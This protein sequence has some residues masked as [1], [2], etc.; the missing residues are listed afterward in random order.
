ML[1][2]PPCAELDRCMLT[3]NQ[4]LVVFINSVYIRFFLGHLTNL[5]PYTVQ[6]DFEPAGRPGTEDDYYQNFKQNICVVCGSK[7]SY[8]RKMIV[9]RDYRRHFPP[10]MKDH[11]SHDILLT[12]PGCHRLAISYDDRLRKELAIKYNAPLGLFIYYINW[13]LYRDFHH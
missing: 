2:N 10:V 9:P 3:T 8:M 5:D 13:M 12:C 1:S 7:E 11:Q 4:L 6:L